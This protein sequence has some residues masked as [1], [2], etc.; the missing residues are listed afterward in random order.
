MNITSFHSTS[1]LQSSLMEKT[2]YLSFLNTVD[3]WNCHRDFVQIEEI[4]NQTQYKILISSFKLLQ[5]AS[6]MKFPIEK[7]QYYR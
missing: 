5:R 6:T 7:S 4:I 2:R 1:Q 3:Q